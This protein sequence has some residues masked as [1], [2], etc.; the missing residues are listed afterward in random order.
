MRIRG[1]GSIQTPGSPPS[2]ASQSA[3]GSFRSVLQQRLSAVREN[4]EIPTQE[5]QIELLN[6]IEDIA[7]RL[8][9]ALYSLEAGDAPEPELVQGLRDLRKQLHRHM[10]EGSEGFTD[11]DTLIAVETHRIEHW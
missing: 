7:Q 11:L 8:D 9:E 6:M 10:P 3:S 2:T 5:T 4:D 1:T